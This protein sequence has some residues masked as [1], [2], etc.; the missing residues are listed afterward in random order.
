[1]APTL[2]VLRYLFMVKR[3][4][5]CQTLCMGPTLLGSIQEQVSLV[6][7]LLVIYKPVP[8]LLCY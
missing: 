2:D 1:M 6:I 3:A 8:C 4:A 5:E 7:F